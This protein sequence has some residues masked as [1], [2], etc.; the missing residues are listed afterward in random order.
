MIKLCLIFNICFLFIF[1]SCHKKEKKLPLKSSEELSYESL[2]GGVLWL[3]K[4]YFN[5]INTNYNGTLYSSQCFF[6]S[7]PENINNDSIGLAIK[8]GTVTVNNKDMSIDRFNNGF[9]YLNHE[10][11]VSLPM[12]FSI[13]SQDGNNLLFYRDYGDKLPSFSNYS[14]IPNSINMHTGFTFTLNNVLNTSSVTVAF[15]GTSIVRTFTNNV[16]YFPP[17]TLDSIGASSYQILMIYLQNANVYDYQV[18]GKKFECNY[19]SNFE[20]RGISI[21]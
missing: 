4:N 7:K 9:R 15:Y 2:G 11:I 8:I 12:D 3:T 6:F 20:Y 19:S 5:Y 21:Y 10:N 14:D 17:A 16:I 1:I 13:K 18:N